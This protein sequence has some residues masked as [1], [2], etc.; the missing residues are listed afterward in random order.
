MKQWTTPRLIFQ[1]SFIKRIKLPL[2]STLYKNTIGDPS[3]VWH[4][5]GSRKNCE[6]QPFKMDRWWRPFVI[7]RNSKN[8]ETSCFADGAQPIG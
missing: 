6:V 4:D 8:P 5:G 3:C 7:P 2:V 1:E